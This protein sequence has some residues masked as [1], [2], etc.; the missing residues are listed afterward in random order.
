[1]KMVIK[2]RLFALVMLICFLFTLSK[3]FW[4][5]DFVYEWGLSAHSNPDHFLWA[6]LLVTMWLISL[7]VSATLVL[8]VFVW[9][10]FCLE[11]R[12]EEVRV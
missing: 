9:L 8:S 2:A 11:E 5:L 4:F 3:S 6:V 12:Y 1:M 10:I 7:T